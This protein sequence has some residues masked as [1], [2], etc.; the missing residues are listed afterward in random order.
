LSRLKTC[1]QLLCFSP[2][3]DFIAGLDKGRLILYYDYNMNIQMVSVTDV[4]RNFKNI[5]D[6]LVPKNPTL[7][8][9]DSTPRAVILSFEEYKRLTQLER[10]A[11]K[12]E[13]SMVMDVLSKKNAKFSDEEIN[14]DI[15]YARKHARGSY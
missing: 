8:I 14:R 15:E 3:G 10:E 9:R 5:L 2:A 1:N 6:N 13:I 4:Q 7:V 11:L 12:K